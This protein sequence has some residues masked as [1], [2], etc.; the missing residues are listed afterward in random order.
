MGAEPERE[1]EL[2][3]RRTKERQIGAGTGEGIGRVRERRWLVTCRGTQ[4]ENGDGNEDGIKEGGG[5][6][7]ERKKPHK[8]C[9]RD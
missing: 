8:T 1:R 9:R 6:A 5:E 4:D 3:W 2:R 7:N